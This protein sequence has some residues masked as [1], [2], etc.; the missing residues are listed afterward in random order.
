MDLKDK[1]AF[2]KLKG[3]LRTADVIVENFRPGV[4]D[5]LGLSD[6]ALRA[7]NPKLIRASISGYGSS[8]PYRD[9]PAMDL[10]IQAI[11][12]VMDTTG[13]ADAPP[14]KAGPAMADFSAGTHL[15]GA[16]LTALLHRERTGEAISTEVAM[17]DAV[18][19]T[20]CSN[21]GLAMGGDDLPARTGNRHGGLSL[22]PYNVYPAADGFVAILCNSNAQWLKLL[23]VIGREH[24]LGADPRLTEM[25][26][27]VQL[28]DYVDAEIGKETSKRLRADLFAALNAAGAPCGA[29][30]TL[31]EVMA[32]PHLRERGM[33]FD[34]EHPVYGRLTLNRSPLRFIG[35]EHVAYDPSHELGAD[36]ALLS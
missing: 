10:T 32:D 23:Q 3:L 34:V 4:M 8:G 17:L 36:D 7:I 30:R 22:C 18:Y 2:E 9:H 25:P 5:R 27:R 21:L 15:Y 1:V 24:D 14:M 29:V 11:S 13:Y 19:P 6:E 33:I 20:L 16:I 31:K 28:M 12:G 35:V 26:G